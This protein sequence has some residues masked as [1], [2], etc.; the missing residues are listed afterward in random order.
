MINHKGNNWKNVIHLTTYGSSGTVCTQRF[1]HFTNAR[2]VSRRVWRHPG[3][4]STIDVAVYMY[5]AHPM[6]STL[7]EISNGKFVMYT[8]SYLKSRVEFLR[9]YEYRQLKCIYYNTS[10]MNNPSLY[11]PLFENR[12]SYK[13]GTSKKPLC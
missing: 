12:N 2:N 10:S 9:F 1:T 7:F 11:W 8:F 4:V 6:L 13:L 5:S 3:R